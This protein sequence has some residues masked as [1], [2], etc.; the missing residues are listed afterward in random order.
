MLNG[1]LNERNTTPRAV[2]AMLQL[3]SHLAP[4]SGAFVYVQ[5][6]ED[7]AD[8]SA[9]HAGSKPCGQAPMAFSPTFCA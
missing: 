5:C 6:G 8:M 2:A 1:S 4:E 7:I 9:R 3:L